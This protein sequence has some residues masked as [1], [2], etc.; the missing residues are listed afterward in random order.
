M[1]T[2]TSCN[3]SG[4]VEEIYQE[5]IETEVS[6]DEDDEEEVDEYKPEQPIKFTKGI[7]DKYIGID[8]KYCHLSPKKTNDNKVFE[9]NKPSKS[10][11]FPHKI[12]TVKNGIDCRSCHKMDDE[13]KEAFLIK[14]DVCAKCHY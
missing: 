8:C 4:D 3:N 7:H 10:S 12:H 1:F 13:P 11:K 14:D 2:V 5:E 9:E 6:S